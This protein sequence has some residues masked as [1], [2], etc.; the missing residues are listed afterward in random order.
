MK[1]TRMVYLVEL[2]I[3]NRL[4]FSPLRRHL[5]QDEQT[6]D[7]AHQLQSHRTRS[8]NRAP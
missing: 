4:F 8:C 5:L 3:S 6:R 1:A 7:K 2:A